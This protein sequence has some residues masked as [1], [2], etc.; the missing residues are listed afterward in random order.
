MEDI[1]ICQ[2]LI[3]PETIAGVS[4]EAFIINIM[5]GVT[6]VMVLEVPYMLMFTLIIH[7][8]LVAICKKDP[9]IL[10]IFMKRYVKQKDYY[11]EG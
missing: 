3:K 1:P 7:F 10:T 9:L 6:F 11:H 4:K 8:I 2:G 5:L